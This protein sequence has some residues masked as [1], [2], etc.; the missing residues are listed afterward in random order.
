MTTTRRVTIDWPLVL[1]ALALTV[2]GIAVVYSAGQTGRPTLVANLYRMQ[3]IWFAIGLCAAYAASRASVRLLDWMT[4]PAYAVTIAVLLAL[5]AFGQ[6]AGTAASTKSW[7]AIGGHRLGQP[8]EL[9][10][11][12]VVLM[13][14]KVLSANKEAPKS[15]VDLWKP[16]LVVG[17]PWLLI[18]LQP[19]LG[20][21]IVFIGI[22]FGM[23]FWSGISWRLLVLIASPVISLVLA[24]GPG[25]DRK[26]VV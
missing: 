26:S 21:G 15:L 12:T 24:F 17:V 9:A 16:A 5:L 2:Y 18:M 22:F 14:A 19:D 23:L 20:T 25:I 10:K 11:I 3:M 8:A 13:L 6:G 4:V 7:L 1:S